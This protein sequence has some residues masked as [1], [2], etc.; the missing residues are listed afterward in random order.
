MNHGVYVSEQAT[1]VSTPNVAASGIPFVVGVAPV[2]SAAKAAKPGVPVMC[3]SWD[4][5]VQQLGY[6]KDWKTYTLCEFMH[7]HFELYGCQPVIFVNVLDISTMKESVEAADLTVT[8]HK[9]QLPIAAINNETLVV[10]AAGGSGG[11][12]V[13]DKDYSTYYDGENL[14]IETIAD[15]DCHDAGQLNVAYTK[16]TPASV[17]E[18]NIATAMESVELCLTT[19]GTVPDLICAPGYS[20][21]PTVAA[22]MATKASGI[23]GLFRAKALIDI[24]SSSGGA[25]TYTAVQEKMKAS[26]LTDKDDICCWPMVK[27]HGNTYHMSTHLAGLMAQVD[28]KNGCPYES[29][30]NK[31]MQVDALC[32]EDGTEVVLTHAQANSLN[33]IGVVTALN[34]N[35]WV[36]WGNYTACYPDNT[37][38]KDNL[39][40]VSRMFDWVANSLVRTFWSKLDRP[41]NRRLIDTVL[42]ASNIWLN[43]LTGAGYLLGARAVMLE[44]E[45]PMENLMAG[46]IKLHIYMTPP[47]P[48]Q[49][50]DFI[51]EYDASY[52]SA[53]QG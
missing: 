20:H 31:P 16:A 4:E 14:V 33:S 44:A 32:L 41:M 29:P 35:G 34:F 52:V 21:K 40:P 6:S 13:L 27:S 23:N 8:D 10:K 11:S 28:T 53:L 42:D 19:L 1:S 3:R 47:A 5:A 50:I 43:G 48:A 25:I 30:S 7:S 15:G 26:N 45:N 36:A 9:V 24:D 2:Q 37:D 46:I 18:V 22:V 17:T 49:E 38:I 12:L 51:L 39:I